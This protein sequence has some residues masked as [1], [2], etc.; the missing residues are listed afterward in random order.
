MILLSPSHPKIRSLVL[1]YL[2]GA[3]DGDADN[4]TVLLDECLRDYAQ[5]RIKLVV[6]RT[7]SDVFAITCL[8]SLYGWDVIEDD[9]LTELKS[10]F[11]NDAIASCAIDGEYDFSVTI[12][13]SN[14][15]SDQTGESCSDLLSRLRILAVGAPLRSAFRRL[16]ITPE[17][18]AAEINSVPATIRVDR[19][20]LRGQGGC[21]HIVRR[22]DRITVVFPVDFEDETDRALARLYLQ[23]FVEGQRKASTKNVAPL[24]DFRWNNPPAEVVSM[25]EKG[26]TNDIAGFLSFTFLRSHVTSETKRERAVE[27]LV[28][29]LT[30]MDYHVKASKTHMHTRMRQK[31]DALQKKLH[32]LHSLN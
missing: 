19:P 23:H 8:C 2:V 15:P 28:L 31:K 25:Y 21:C 32:D 13:S 18:D 22:A 4:P 11:G 27:L 7:E 1:P 16:H 10:V 9:A 29:F 26:V 12:E 17:A 5:T 3:V 30:Y 14:L 24:V 20:T 6:R